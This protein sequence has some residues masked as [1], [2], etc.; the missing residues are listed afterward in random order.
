MQ[1]A[2]RLTLIALIRN[3]RHFR[4]AGGYFFMV[5][6]ISRK[7]YASMIYNTNCS[8]PIE[9]PPFGG[10]I[11]DKSSQSASV[12][13]YMD[14]KRDEQ[15]FALIGTPRLSAPCIIPPL[16]YFVNKTPPR[17]PSGMFLLCFQMF[18]ECRFQRFRGLVAHYSCVAPLY[19]IDNLLQ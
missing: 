11:R 4:G 13:S 12:R 1:R 19:C 16:S 7:M 17:S 15:A 14:A 3:N 9:I 18:K 5:L 2:E 10:E 6:K 8:I